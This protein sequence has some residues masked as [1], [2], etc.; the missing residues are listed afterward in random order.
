VR[1]LPVADALHDRQ[2]ILRSD[3]RIRL[4]RRLKNGGAK[5]ADGQ[6]QPDKKLAKK[7]F[8]WLDEVKWKMFGKQLKMVPLP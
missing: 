7:H 3:V 1:E 5:K 2:N 8:H 4:R 6:N